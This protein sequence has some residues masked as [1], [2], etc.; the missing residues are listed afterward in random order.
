MTP[1]KII[2]VMTLITVFLVIGYVLNEL[3]SENV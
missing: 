1:I 3:E 2:S